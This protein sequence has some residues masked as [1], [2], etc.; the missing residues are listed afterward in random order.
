MLNDCQVASKRACFTQVPFCLQ[1]VT[2]RTGEEVSYSL[3]LRKKRAGF[4]E[5]LEVI[6]NNDLGLPGTS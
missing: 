6:K 2:L 5:G 3:G 1:V 4:P